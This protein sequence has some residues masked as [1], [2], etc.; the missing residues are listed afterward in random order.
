MKNMDVLTREQKE[1]IKLKQS[2]ESMFQDVMSIELCTPPPRRIK[3]KPMNYTVETHF[4]LYLEIL[5]GKHNDFLQ[6]IIDKTK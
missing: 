6:Q 2:M 3:N 1:Y 4:Y 5:E